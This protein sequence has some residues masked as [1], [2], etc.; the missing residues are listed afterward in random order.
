MLKRKNCGAELNKTDLF[1]K[2]CGKTVSKLSRKYSVISTIFGVLSAFYS[3]C[4]VW[5]V[6]LQMIANSINSNMRFEF[7]FY[8]FGAIGLTVICVVVSFIFSNISV[9]RGYKTKA[10]RISKLL[11][12]SSIAVSV[13][14]TIIGLLLL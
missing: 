5:S 8:Q 12:I 3:F 10:T 6:F 11:C 9:K 4:I 1:C 2:Q 13:V 14:G 7:G